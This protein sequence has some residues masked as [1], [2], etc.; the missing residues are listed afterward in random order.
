MDLVG[1]EPTISVVCGAMK[2]GKSH[3]IKHMVNT[4]AKRGGI[5]SVL[6]FSGTASFSQQS[7]YDF[8]PD[9]F[10]HGIYNEKVLKKYLKLHK[11]NVGISGLVIFDDVQG[12]IDTQSAFFQSFITNFRHY[13]VSVII[14]SQYGKGSSLPPYIRNLVNYFVHFR[15]ENQDYIKQLWKEHGGLMKLQEFSDMMLSIQ[16]HEYLLIDKMR[17][18]ETGK[19]LIAKAPAL[20]KPFKL[21]F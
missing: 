16:K 19:Y 2:C 18:E 7:N 6:V 1:L 10:V 15:V 3:L 11:D 17:D 9:K 20:I 4:M 5:N 8:I 21:S 13:R 14:A 12:Q